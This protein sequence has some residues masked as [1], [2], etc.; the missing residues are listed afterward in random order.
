MM[1]YD[2]VY[3]EKSWVYHF[4]LTLFSGDKEYFRR[5]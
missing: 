3:P 1:Q 2:M 5:I 4:V